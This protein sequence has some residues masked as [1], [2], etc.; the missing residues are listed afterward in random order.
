MKDYLID[1]H[2][3]IDMLEEPL[4]TTLNLMAEYGVKKA[5][6]PSVEVATMDKVISLA[7][8]KTF[9]AMS[10]IFPTEAASYNEVVENKIRE[11]ADKIV[12]I[13]E[14]GLDYY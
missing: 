7:D 1:T 11:C 12:A 4:E 9:Y 8:N 3:H 10:G 5:V 14:I 6:I 13:G 2:A